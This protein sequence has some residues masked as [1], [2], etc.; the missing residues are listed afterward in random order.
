MKYNI[1]TDIQLNSRILQEVTR[2][3]EGV[4]STILR[5]VFDT[6]DKQAQQAL[7]EMGWIPP[8]HKERIG[9]ILID[10]G[11]DEA[12]AIYMELFKPRKE[13]ILAKDIELKCN[14]FRDE[15]LNTAKDVREMM[16][17]PDFDDMTKQAYEGQHGE[18]KA[19][20]MLTYRHLEDARMRV[21][22]ILQALGDGVSILDHKVGD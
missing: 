18:M 12:L 20:I 6:A 8:A 1:K 4:E 22:K 13:T 5:Q 19:N 9:K 17:H 11:T 14:R 3:H 21:G 2:E 15:I 16:K 10:Q 7:V